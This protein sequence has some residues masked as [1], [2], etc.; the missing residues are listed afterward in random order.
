MLIMFWSTSTSGHMDQ[1][2]NIAERYQIP[3]QK[4]V[5]ALAVLDDHGKLIYSQRTG[6]FEKMRHMEIGSCHQLSAA[7]EAVQGWDVDA[8]VVC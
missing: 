5:P 7:M 1:N 8:V 6:E 2:Q 3:L 4:G